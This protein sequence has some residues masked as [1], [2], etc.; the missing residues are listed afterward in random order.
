MFWRGEDHPFSIPHTIPAH[1]PRTPSLQPLHPRTTRVPFPKAQSDWLPLRRLEPLTRVSPPRLCSQNLKAHLTGRRGASDVSSYRQLRMA[2]D[3]ASGMQFLAEHNVVH[4]D[5]A[6]R[7]CLIDQD[8]TVKIGDFGL[9]RSK[10]S[11]DYF[12][13][14][15]T[16]EVL[17]WRWMSPQAIAAEGEER[18]TPANDIWAF[19]VTAWEIT[20]YANQPYPSLSSAEVLA[21]VQSG[22]TMTAAKGAAEGLADLIAKCWAQAEGERPGFEAIV[23]ALEVLAEAAPKNSAD[24]ARIGSSTSFPVMEKNRSSSSLGS[25]AYA[26]PQDKLKR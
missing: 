7:N 4:A 11:S 23:Q 25:G 6:T 3:I 5:L 15:P 14:G 9:T 8:H 16:N 20:T 19:G 21:F 17:A 24:S 12:G 2:C 22:K 18:W 26:D 13:A 10:F 1:H